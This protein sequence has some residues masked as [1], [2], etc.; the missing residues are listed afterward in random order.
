MLR[1]C[2]DHRCS[3]AQCAQEC[4]GLRAERIETE[5]G[6]RE[7]TPQ[8]AA[9]TDSEL[10]RTE[11]LGQKEAAKLRAVTRR[12]EE[13]EDIASVLLESSLGFIENEAHAMLFWVQAEL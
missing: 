5:K 3:C 11:A 9:M 6:L 8:E 12:T 2:S 10:S 1:R 13:L 7:A 4:R